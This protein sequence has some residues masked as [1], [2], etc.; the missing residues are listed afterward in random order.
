MSYIVAVLFLVLTIMLAIATGILIKTLSSNEVLAEMFKN[1]IKTLT[2][3]LF[4]FSFSYMLR[5]ILDLTLAPWM[6]D[7]F[8]KD[9]YSSNY[10]FYLSLYQILT[11]YVY[12]LIPISCILFYHVRNFR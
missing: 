5:L 9:Y 4:A 12:D 10:F 8:Q 7:K 6:L 1:E 2:I 11:A 3:I